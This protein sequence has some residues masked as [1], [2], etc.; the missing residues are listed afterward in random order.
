MPNNKPCKTTKI[1][2]TPDPEPRPNIT[3]VYGLAVIISLLASPAI[4]L[5]FD[6]HWAWVVPLYC[7]TTSVLVLL[8]SA[9]MYFTRKNQKP[10]SAFAVA[11][12]KTLK[13]HPKTR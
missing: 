5:H 11:A 9:L 13:I 1:S 7:L 2:P 3:S 10:E 8:L 6:L 12:T 4:I